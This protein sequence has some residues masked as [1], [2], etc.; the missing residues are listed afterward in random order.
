M[1]LSKEREQEIL[2]Q[3]IMKLHRAVDN[4]ISRKT[5]TAVCIPY[6]DLLQEACIAYLEYIRKCDTEEQLDIFP[7]Y[8]VKNGM[9]RLVVMMQPLSIPVR[10]NGFQKMVS[11]MPDTVSYDVLASTGMEI[12]GMSKYWVDDTDTKLDFI[13]FMNEQYGNKFRQHL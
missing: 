8:D 5:S 2:E 1:V 3:N 6:E 12:D 4:F 10:T 7:W 9:L 13:S 11:S